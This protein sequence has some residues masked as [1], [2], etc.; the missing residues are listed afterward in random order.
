M[1]AFQSLETQTNSLYKYS[2]KNMLK[3]SF[4]LI[5]SSLFIHTSF[6]QPI[7]LTDNDIDNDG[8]PDGDTNPPFTSIDNC[9]TKYNPNQADYDNDG[10]GD[11]CDNCIFVSNAAQ[12]ILHSIGDACLFL[13]SNGEPCEGVDTDVYPGVD[14]CLKD[15]PDTDGDGIPDIFDNCISISNP[16]QTDNDKDG[17]GNA[18]DDDIDGDGTPNDIDID[19]DELYYADPPLGFVNDS[20]IDAVDSCPLVFNYY[21]YID[22]DGD[23]IGDFVYDS[24]YGFTSGCDNCFNVFNPD[25]LDSDGDGHGDACDTC[26]EISNPDQTNTDSDGVGDACDNCPFIQNAD[27]SDVDSDGVGD[28]CDNCPLVFN[29]DQ[30]DS[31]GDG[32]GDACDDDEC[33][34]CALHVALTSLGDITVNVC[35]D[36][37]TRRRLG[38]RKG[39]SSDSGGNSDSVDLSDLLVEDEERE[40]IPQCA[41]YG[42]ER[43]ITCSCSSDTCG[44]DDECF[45]SGEA[46]Y[47]SVGTCC[48]NVCD[49]NGGSASGSSDSGEVEFVSSEWTKDRCGVWT[50]IFDIGIGDSTSGSASSDGTRRRMLSSDSG[51]N[52]ASSEDIDDGDGVIRFDD[53]LIETCIEYEISQVNVIDATCVDGITIFLPLCENDDVSYDQTLLDVADLTALIVSTGTNVLNAQGAMFDD[54]LGIEIELI[55]NTASTFELCLGNISVSAENIDDL[56]IDSIG[57]STGQLIVNDIATSCDNMDGLPCFDFFF[58]A[59]CPDGIDFDPSLY[60]SCEC[61]DGMV[62]VEFEYVGDAAAASI[63]FIRDK[64]YEYAT[65]AGVVNGDLMTVVSEPKDDKFRKY[66]YVS[67]VD[68]ASGEQICDGRIRKCKAYI[69]DSAVD[70]CDALMVRSWTDGDGALCDAYAINGLDSDSADNALV[71]GD[72]QLKV[73][74]F[75][76]L[77]DLDPFVKYSLIGIAV[78]FFVMIIVAAYVCLIRKSTEQ[79]KRVH[80]EELDVEEIQSKDGAQ[81]TELM[82]IGASLR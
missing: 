29:P 61:D 14:A 18:C 1:P 34:E 51:S 16:V 39:S 50:Q 15:I 63:T 11:V 74:V 25:Q 66:F 52:S 30:L 75:Q 76:T 44:V 43:D 69:I 45:A 22:M 10:V 70:G 20:V 60:R 53:I 3:F 38:L 64:Y 33:P 58:E 81:Q 42:A 19:D 62:A 54:V 59:E 28:V 67:V 55:D 57:T 65:F 48:C 37:A 31:D 27:Q 46:G 40:C 35:P 32:I 49:A 36:D 80:T 17:V 8:I 5:S 2:S 6:A 7:D 73:G 56:N 71:S 41:Q 12:N 24:Y 47:C 9:R 23:G 21:D 26:P 79:R 82:S 77:A 78:V 72:K 68:E 4:L 13:D